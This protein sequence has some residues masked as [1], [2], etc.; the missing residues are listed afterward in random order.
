MKTKRFISLL[1]TLALFMG[2]FAIPA[3]ASHVHE[4][5]EIVVVIENDEL[6]DE[7]K[8]KI[9]AYYTDDNHDDDTA[10]YGL[11]CTLLGHK[12]EHTSTY[13]ITHKA[14]STAPRC[15]KKTY[16]HAACTRCDYQESTVRTSQYIY[17]CS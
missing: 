8:E 10:T 9:I 16:D 5:D 14:R 17:C 11:T 15:L 7:M 2:A 3:S 6:S 1:L 13:T 4:T 12:L